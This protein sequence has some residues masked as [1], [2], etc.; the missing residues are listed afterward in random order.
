MSES[1]MTPAQQMEM[2]Q[3]T[4][5]SLGKSQIQR[6]LEA[7]L[8]DLRTKLEQAERERDDYA[9]RLAA[10]DVSWSQIATER[11]DWRRG[12]EN[13]QRER[14]KYVIRES[15]SYDHLRRDVVGCRDLEHDA[16]PCLGC[17][18]RVAE[19]S[20]NRLISELQETTDGAMRVSGE[21]ARLREALMPFS[22][23][24]FSDFQVQ[25][26]TA[27]NNIKYGW[28]A[29]KAA[30]VWEARTVLAETEEK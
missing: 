27:D 13:A 22:M 18:L 30:D 20:M 17:R 26:A 8:D 15:L 1:K 6:C 19:R 12:S 9:T 5:V 23:P 4:M 25:M 14:D 16:Q 29:F 10:T 7:A 28:I 24:D 3:K 21:R 2:A 11:D